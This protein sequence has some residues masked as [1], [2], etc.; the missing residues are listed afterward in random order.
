MK[1]YTTHIQTW[2]CCHGNRLLN[3]CLYIFIAS[4]HISDNFSK[5]GVVLVRLGRIETT[6][7]VLA[8][9]ATATLVQECR[10]AELTK[11]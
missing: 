4:S 6:T 8:A 2:G 1:N 3:I 5:V 10:C 7:L 11:W 9:K